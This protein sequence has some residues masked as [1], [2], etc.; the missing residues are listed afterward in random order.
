[1]VDGRIVIGRKSLLMNGKMLR[2]NK[3]DQA[4]S[5]A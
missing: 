5:A 2:C 3:K 1:M 4:C